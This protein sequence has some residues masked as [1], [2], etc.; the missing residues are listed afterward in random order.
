MRLKRKSILTLVGLCVLGALALLVFTEHRRGPL[1][2]AEADARLLET[3][4]RLE[5]VERANHSA[6]GWFQKTG[7][8]NAGVDSAVKS[9]GVRMVNA[10]QK[11]VILASIESAM[12]HTVAT[13]DRFAQSYDDLDRAQAAAAAL[14]LAGVSNA[15]IRSPKQRDGPQVYDVMV[16][17]EF[18]QTVVDAALKT[19]IKELRIFSDPI[20]G[21]EAYLVLIGQG[22]A[23]TIRNRI[24]PANEASIRRLA[25]LY[26]RTEDVQRAEAVLKSKRPDL[27][28]SH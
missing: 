7:L 2:V 8:T 1:T 23:A 24:P 11:E 14:S 16:P 17:H 10:M 6:V 27:S 28:V 19:S 20:D 3:R 12:A 25:V 15:V 4:K 18:D 9:V 26:V 22:I 5:Q 13:A 21:A